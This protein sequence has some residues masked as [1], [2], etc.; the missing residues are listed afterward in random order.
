MIGFLGVTGAGKSTL[1]NSILGLE[2]LL[3]A[4]DEKACTAVI[5]EISWNPRDDP[6]AEF[7]A[8]ID[9]ISKEE[10]ESELQKLFQ[11]IADK[12]SNKD[13]DG[14]EPDL[15][16]DER[17]KSAFGKVRCVYPS[18]KSI[19]VLQRFTVATLMGHCNVRGI[20]GESKIIHSGNLQDFGDAIKPYIDSS[21]SKE[22]G[23]TYSFAQWPL[24]KLVRLQVKA[25]VLE[26]GI[27]L[28][29]LPGSMD[30]N[31]ARGALAATYTKNLTVSCVVSPT[32]RA[33][34]DKPVSSFLMPPL[35][36]YMHTNDH[37]G[38]RTTWIYHK[39]LLATGRSFHK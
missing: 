32:S 36:V 20:L 21:D 35:F 18:I 27:V 12:I 2:D 31:V 24:V 23:G 15:E 14:E 26:T 1:I 39:A 17:I 33:A 30:T 10:W 28:V 34:S 13:G 11:D 5:C 38:S 25:E 8:I 37:Q 29:D 19:E 3:P 22:D 16:R 6:K 4:D 9:R 7:V